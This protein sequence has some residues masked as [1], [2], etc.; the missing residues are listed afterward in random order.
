MSAPIDESAARR[1]LDDWSR[2][3]FYQPLEGELSALRRAGFLAPECFW[4]RGPTT[5]YGAIRE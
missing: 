4:K 5:I 3:D 2:E 1:H